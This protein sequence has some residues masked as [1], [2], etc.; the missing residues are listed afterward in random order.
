MKEKIL[1]LIKYCHKAYDRGYVGGTGGNLSIRIGDTM[2]I[3]SSGSILGDMTEDDIVAVPLNDEKNYTSCGGRVPSKE[4]P[5]HLS[6]YRSR[7]DINAIVH[8]HPA[9]VIAAMLTLD[10]VQANMPVYVPGFIYKHGIAPQVD[11]YR[12]GSLELCQNVSEKFLKADCVLMRKHGVIVGDKSLEKAFCCIEDVDDNCRIHLI[13]RGK[14]AL[15]SQEID[16]MLN[17]AKK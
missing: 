10:D 12:A 14:N 5:L 11:Y 6:I 16:N 1:K 15:T 4:A 9:N 13:L 8:L 17:A 7:P 2:Y 3:S